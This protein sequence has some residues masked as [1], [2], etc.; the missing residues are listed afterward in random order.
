ML[1]FLL[2]KGAPSLNK[3]P[4]LLPII[5]LLGR[6]HDRLAT[7]L[8]HIYPDWTD[9]QLFFES[10]AILTAEWQTIITNEVF[11]AILGPYWS[12]HMGLTLDDVDDN[13]HRLCKDDSTGPADN[14]GILILELLYLT[15][16]RPIMQ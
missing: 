16:V 8:A 12:E 4:A 9:D 6:E 10:R 1:D 2:Y 7:I 3:Q 14:A 13:Y 15:T 11:P 5:T